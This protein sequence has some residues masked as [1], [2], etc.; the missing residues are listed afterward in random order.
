MA[1]DATVLEARNGQ[2]HGL[3]EWDNASHAAIATSNAQVEA[4]HAQRDYYVAARENLRP[5]PVPVPIAVQAGHR[6]PVLELVGGLGVLAALLVAALMAQY[7]L[8]TRPAPLPLP[9]NPAPVVTTEAMLAEVVQMTGNTVSIQELARS[10]RVRVD[11]SRETFVSYTFDPSSRALNRPADATI[12]FAVAK[13]W[14]IRAQTP[15]GTRTYREGE[16]GE[17]QA[18]VGAF[19]A[20]RLPR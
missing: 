20:Y 9:P 4:A 14:I 3:A 17:I 12:V 18:Q 8:T 15:F 10:E 7:L 5:A 11:G 19:E 13:G 2:E 6:H 1:A 16:Q